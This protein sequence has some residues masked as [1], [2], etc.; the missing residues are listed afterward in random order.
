MKRLQRLLA[1]RSIA[2]VG[3]QWAD[4]VGRQCQRLGYPGTLWRI[5]TRREAQSD[6]TCCW[7][8]LGALPAVPD[9]VFVGVNRHTTL[10]IVREARAIGA[11]G[12]ICFASG[13]SELHTEEGIALSAALREAAG[14]MP[15]LGPNCYGAVNYLD[16]VGLFPDQL[17]LRH[18]D[19][20]V[21]IIS[22][23]GT[24]ACNTLYADRSLPIAAIV[25][26]GNQLCL[27]ISD[28]VDAALDDSRIT[29]IGAYLESLPDPAR[30]RDAVLRARARGI[31]VVLC[32]AGRSESARRTVYTHTGAI[33]GPERYT[34]ALLERLGV[35]RCETLAE[36]IETLKCLHTGGC[37]SGPNIL[38]CGASGG[39]MALAADQ[40]D[41]LALRMPTL[42]ESTRE[43]L[44]GILGRQVTLANPLDFQTGIWHD[45][46]ALRAM[47][48]A[49]FD[50][51]MDGVVFVLDH[52]QGDGLDASSFATPLRCF[53][54]AARHRQRRDS[55]AATLSAMPESLPAALRDECLACGVVP[56]QGMHEGLRAIDHA[57][58][59]RQKSTPPP[60]AL[61]RPGVDASSPPDDTRDASPEYRAM[62]ATL[63][64]A[65]AKC[66]LGRAGIPVPCGQIVAIDEAVPTARRIGYPVA[67]KISDASLAHKSDVGGVF[68]NL[69]TDEAVQAA[70]ESLGSLG[71]QVLIEPMIGNGVAELLLG[72]DVD[73]H[74]GPVVLV[75]A[76]GTLAELLDDTAILLPPYDEQ[77]ARSAIASL[78]IARLL[79]G[80]RGQAPGDVDAVVHALMRL[81]ELLA[82]PTLQTLV[83]LDINP[84]CV[85]PVGQ[86]VMALDALIRLAGQ[87]AP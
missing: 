38:V 39:D 83:E 62:P 67:M 37:L 74:F 10:D 20:G 45:A 21:F 42:P 46:A 71:R 18:P 3:G 34:D 70:T 27:D 33:G 29:A 19:R 7:P 64:E 13:F 24:I 50:T 54:D 17:P 66:I 55:V 49:L 36:F 5:R 85:R 52:P 87:P 65:E 80:W 9:C 35:P 31:P 30:L 8:S 72:V 32:K 25:T 76:G 53:L 51:A 47:F 28:L 4:T 15:L 1:P 44:A 69:D 57:V 61:G 77:A 79:S 82:D 43:R 40:L 84:L 56:L 48:D 12:V 60:P 86:G 68:L 63:T 78:R 2:L 59:R 6:D 41:G 58:D 26:V 73:R 11:G 75:A 14:D 16:R 81:Q 23:S 22:Q